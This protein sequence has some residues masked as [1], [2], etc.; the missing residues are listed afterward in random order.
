V[1]TSAFR[2]VL[3]VP[4]TR[5]DRFAKALDS[6][7]DAVI[8]DLED[9]VEAGKKGD[10]RK[11]LA[12][13]FGGPKTE[14]PVMRLIRCNVVGSRWIKD[15][16]DLIAH[17]PADGIVVPKVETPAQIDE[18]ARSGASRT[19]VP[20]L[21]TARGVLNAMSIANTTAS[22]PALLFGA[23]DL[24]AQMGIPRT[25][26]GEELVF[27][28]S[29]IALA[30]T[31]IG[32]VAVDAVF[33]DIN[34]TDE[35]RRDAERARAL[36]FRGKMCIHPAQVPI[37]NDVF[38]PSAEE[39]EKAQRIVDAYEAARVRGEGVIRLDDQM[40]DAPVAARAKRLL[41]MKRT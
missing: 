36:G 25:L 23:E 16:L 41:E 10:A 24:T 26:D 9:S 22:I 39:L 32:A 35:L 5:P 14:S 15:D 34:K 8:F 20:I 13:F 21:E 30:A 17:L 18:I 7:A 27:A 2:S 3:F 19:I 11:Q 33:I 29:Q 31:T 38:T 28:R 4:S 37:V 6:G 1:K 40:I 12:L